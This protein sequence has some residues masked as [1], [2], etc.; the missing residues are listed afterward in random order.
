MTQGAVIRSTRNAAMKVSVSAMRDFGDQPPAFGTAA[1]CAGH[2]GLGAGL[3]DEDQP[4]R[5]KPAL[6]LP[7]LRASSRHLGAVLLGGARAFF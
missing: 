5:I 6:I 1:V 4:L 2:V 3:V 7:P